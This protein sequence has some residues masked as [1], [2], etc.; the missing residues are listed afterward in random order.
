MFDMKKEYQGISK[1]GIISLL[2]FLFVLPII[3]ANVPY[4]DDNTR[5]DNGVAYWEYEGR[6]LTTILFKIL[7][8]NLYE[9]ANVAP[10]PLLIG[11]FF[12][13]FTINYAT[14]KMS[15]KK[16]IFNIIPFTFIICNPFF[17]QNMSYQFDSIGHLFSVGFIILSLFYSSD[18]KYKQHIF[19]VIAV[20][21]SCASYQP[22]SNLYIGLYC[23]IFLFD[24]NR[25]K[26]EK[27][28]THIFRYISYYI[29]GCSIYYLLYFIGFTYFF[30]E[31]S[32]R[33]HIIN[34]SQLFLSYKISFNEFLNLY[35][36]IN[37]GLTGILINISI[38]FIL[39]NVLFK[40]FLIYKK[41]ENRSERLVKTIFTLLIP[42]G[43]VFSILGPF[44]LLQ[45]LFFNPRDFPSVGAFFMVFGF[46]FY[47]FDFHNYLKKVFI[48][49]WLICLFSFSFMY[50]NAL[51]YDNNY[52]QYV[53][54]SIARDLELHSNE[55]K[56]K[57]IQVYGQNAM[58]SYIY[59]AIEINPFIK[60]LIFPENTNFVKKYNL[61]A[62]NIYNVIGG[63]I[64]DDYN[65][66]N[67]ICHNNTSPLVKNGNYDIF[68]FEDHISVWFKNNP[69]LCS[70]IPS[71]VNS[72]FSDK[73]T[74]LEENI[75]NN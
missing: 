52:K 53:Y 59:H 51:H 39:T 20:I 10:M 62:R 57:K 72:K 56:D 8:F 23:V 18:N 71:D 48:F 54:D 31:I 17:L 45:E 36:L 63:V 33:N 12:V 65:E 15:A 29:L 74:I 50:G 66:W 40:S 14:D 25:S 9:I 6:P 22:T 60:A 73:K 69:N 75:N 26:Y 34:F 61:S 4:M 46:S 37:H 21:L 11:L 16:T 55:I 44:V 67:N 58:T 5:M 41:E 28:L 27:S 2:C 30:V 7:N 47:Y 38:I 35:L 19:P 1:I 49:L 70:N 64:D 13:I 3:I 43:L 24:L 68:T 42:F 32:N